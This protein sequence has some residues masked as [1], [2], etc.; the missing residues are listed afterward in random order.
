M[1]V[2]IIQYTNGKIAAGPLNNGL[3]KWKHLSKECSNHDSGNRPVN[4]GSSVILQ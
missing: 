1:K 4:Q 2:L 3:P